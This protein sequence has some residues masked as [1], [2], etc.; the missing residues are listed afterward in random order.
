MPFPKIFVKIAYPIILYDEVFFEF[1][2]NAIP[3]FD[4]DFRERRFLYET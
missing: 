2:I 1:Y 3:N 4:E